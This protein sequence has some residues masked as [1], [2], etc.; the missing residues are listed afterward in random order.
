M[1]N[2]DYTMKNKFCNSCRHFHRMN[3]PLFWSKLISADDVIRCCY[4]A[5]P[6]NQGYCTGHERYKDI[7]AN[8]FYIACNSYEEVYVMVDC[9]NCRN[10]NLVGKHTG[11]CE[12]LILK[13]VFRPYCMYFGKFMFNSPKECEEYKPRWIAIEKPIR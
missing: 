3:S 6:S 4:A 1:G 11:S 8:E 5:F 2:R 9:F 13:E 10:V 7:L 12:S